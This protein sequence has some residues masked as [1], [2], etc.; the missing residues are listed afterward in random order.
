MDVRIGL[1]DGDDAIR[2]GRRLALAA[3]STG[4]IVFESSSADDTLGRI[5][6]YLIDVLVVDQRIQGMPGVELVAKV[7]RLKTTESFNTSI[8]MTAPFSNSALKLAALRAGAHQLVSQQDG[9][10]ALFNSVRRVATGEVVVSMQ[11]LKDLWGSSNQDVVFDRIL[12]SRIEEFAPREREYIREIASGELV[13]AVAK[14]FEVSAYRV[15]KPL[16]RLLAELNLQTLEQL[17]LRFLDAG[18]LN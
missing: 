10:A 11:E 15:R 14:K 16:E 5:A 17:Q 7:S 2:E 18:L 13:S 9:A 12:I 6:D 4:N 1:V 8:I 3:S